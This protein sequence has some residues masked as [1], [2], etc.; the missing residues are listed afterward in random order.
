MAGCDYIDHTYTVQG[1]ETIQFCGLVGKAPINPNP[2]LEFNIISSC[3]RCNEPYPCNII[4]AIT[5]V[6]TNNMTVISPLGTFPAIY[7][8]TGWGIGS[9]GNHTGRFNNVNNLPDDP[10]GLTTGE[11]Y[12]VTIELSVTMPRDVGFW[13]GRSTVNVGTTPDLI[14]PMGSTFISANLPWNP[15]SGGGAVTAYFTKLGAN[16]SPGWN[17]IVT[18]N[19]YRGNCGTPPL[20][21]CQ[22]LTSFSRSGGSSAMSLGANLGNACNIIMNNAT[23]GRYIQI[24]LSGTSG[25]PIAGQTYYV[26]IDYTTSISYGQGA[27]GFIDLGD[28]ATGGGTRTYF[29][30]NSAGTPIIASGV[31]GT[32]NAGANYFYLQ[33]PSWTG[34]GT[35]SGNIYVTVGIGTCP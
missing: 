11:T 8:C 35:V 31:W 4:D 34:G 10:I 1:L 24:G 13:F 32:G 2:K 20:P 12:Y 18:I 3:D 7:Q 22:Y 5:A 23:F 21:T 16:M 17:G 6:A 25:T 15:L 29:S 26:Q 33:L 30:M 19:V 27:T 14:L 28:V 9:G